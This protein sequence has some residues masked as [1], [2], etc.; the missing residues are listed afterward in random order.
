MS[1]ALVAGAACAVFLV[2]YLVYGRLL[3]RLYALDDRAQTPAHKVNDGVDFV[4]AKA[5]LLL[6]QHFSAIAAA[7][8][9]VG[10]ILAG[11]WFGWLPALLWIV[12]GSVFFG[13]VHD[14]SSLVGSVRHKAASVAQIVKEQMG[15]KA[16]N[17]F[18]AF[19]W[20][21]LIYVITAFA[22]ITSA[23]FVEAQYGGG[24]AAS[25]SLYLVLG[26][27]MGLCLRRR[28]PLWLATVIFVPLVGA[29][30]WFG[31]AIPLAFPADGF[32]RPQLLWNYIILAYCFVASII[33][34]W[35]LLQPR[36]YLGGFFLYGA[37]IAG[38]V[39]LFLG[40]DRVQYPAF[41]GWTNQLKGIPLFPML[42][43]TVAC[44]ACSGFHGLVSSGTTSKQVARET[45]CRLVGYG[46]M[47]LEGLVAVIALAT[48]MLLAPGD[49]ATA[50]SPDRIYAN[51]LSHFVEQ[52]GINAQ[53]ARSFALLAFATFIYDTL[54][55][56]T[57]LGRYVL[58]ELTGWRGWMG[59]MAATLLT[60]APPAYFV[61]VTLHDASGQV[62]PAWR[63]FWTIFGT[64]NQLLAGLTLLGLTLWL[65]KSRKPW[66]I[67]AVPMGF[68][69]SMT[70][71]ALSRAFWP[72]VKD[73][74]AGQL[75]WKIIPVVALVLM[76]LALLLMWESVKAL[77][78]G[79]R[80]TLPP[81][82]RAQKAR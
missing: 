2:A 16:Y 27:A 13:A 49:P 23:S 22:D 12:L 63:M 58:Q 30:I 21:S 33:P 37:L 7:G 48:V 46:G 76:A 70:L 50:S 73:V 72:W 45:D 1:L 57:R 35:V 66:W 44:G 15:A 82:A 29:V 4:P 38:V 20:F 51:G 53:F 75:E 69:L 28:M 40:G 18:L 71:W 34:V 17:F 24:V 5:P 55:V 11:L 52:F 59:S 10:P 39:G 80:P 36:G 26:V 62:I 67:T 19:V 74:A 32:L 6:G 42:F 31:Q 81:V 78:W 68:M 47:L 60:L 8:P 25:S 56:A 65:K 41:L 54:D 77:G 43:V 61:S 14:F 64:S 3:A 9:I 79:S